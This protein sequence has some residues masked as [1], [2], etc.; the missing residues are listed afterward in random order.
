MQA[1]TW[2]R[3]LCREWKHTQNNDADSEDDN[4][5]EDENE[6]NYIEQLPENTAVHMDDCYGARQHHHN[7]RPMRPK[8]YGHLHVEVLDSFDMTQHSMKKGIKMF[9]NAGVKAVHKE[10]QQL[11][12]RDVIEPVDQKKMTKEERKPL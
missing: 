12:D 5:E 9:G 2:K 7:L 6:D 1:R 10:L 4:E 8:D 3:E 11:H